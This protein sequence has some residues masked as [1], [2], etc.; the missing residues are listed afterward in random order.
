MSAA[1]PDPAKGER[2][3]T[4]FE[5]AR[6]ATIPH[7]FVQTPERVLNESMSPLIHPPARIV[8]PTLD[9]PC[10]RHAIGER[11]LERIPLIVSELLDQSVGQTPTGSTAPV[12][13]SMVQGNEK[14]KLKALAALIKWCVDFEEKAAQRAVHRRE[15]STD[16]GRVSG[17][18]ALPLQVGSSGRSGHVGIRLRGRHG[19]SLRSSRRGRERRTNPASG[20]LE[21]GIQASR[22]D[23]ER[24]RR[25]ARSRSSLCERSPR[26]RRL[27]ST[28]QR[29]METTTWQTRS[30]RPS[31]GT[32]ST[33]GLPDNS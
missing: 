9:D 16:G 17:W 23:R 31:A 26:S 28:R 27:P 15:C 24:P 25:P 11:L 5:T 22:R 3:A 30:R 10:F 2:F 6:R 29:R 7:V 8:M 21:G 19:A 13:G 4:A 20:F 33:I 14:A 32:F 1:V 12:L 18:S